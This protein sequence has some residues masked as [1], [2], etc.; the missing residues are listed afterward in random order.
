MLRLGLLLEVKQEMIDIKL[1][2]RM[3]TVG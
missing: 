3:A 1:Q 2:G